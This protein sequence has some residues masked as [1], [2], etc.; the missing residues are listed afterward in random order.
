[1]V[2][3]WSVV[4]VDDWAV[5]GIENQG[6]HQHDWLRH[7]EVGARTWL[8][9]PAR[10]ARDR[11]M[12]ED[13]V[14][15]LG[16]ELARLVGVPVPRVELA[17]RNGT[18]GALVEDARLPGWELQ[19][20]QVLM[21]EVVSDYEPRDPEHTGYNVQNVRRALE[22][23]AV[24]PESELPSAFSAF[25]A[26]AGYLLF[27]A[28]IAHGDRHERNWAVILPPPGAAEN[29]ALCASFDHAASLGFTLADDKRAQLL[30]G[31]T[32][33]VAQ[34]ASRGRARCFE[35]RAGERCQTLVELAQ[36]AIALCMSETREHWRERILSVQCGPVSD[37]VA[38]APDLSDFTRRFIVELVVVNR[39][40]LLDVLR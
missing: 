6:M 39:G 24:P 1:M 22:R 23:F 19:L 8:F 9:K 16:C 35:H 5:A 36:S 30:Q 38:A 4:P 2:A 34:W 7:P 3:Q 37:V 27:D 10:P 29:E 11:S 26:F 14:E 25:D 12:R 13:L 18:A 32:A 21:P 20:G 33:A 15:K 28:L 17:S 40:R 31:G